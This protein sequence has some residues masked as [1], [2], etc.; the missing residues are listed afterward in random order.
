MYR[1]PCDSP[2][3]RATTASTA[4]SSDHTGAELQV[5]ESGPT[6]V[7]APESGST[8]MTTRSGGSSSEWR[9]LQPSAIRVPLVSHASWVGTGRP[10]PGASTCSISDR[11][12]SKTSVSSAVIESISCH[13][14]VNCRDRGCP[15]RPAPASGCTDAGAIREAR[16]QAP[17]RRSRRVAAR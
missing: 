7:H 16:R 9:T 14:V 8:D 4:P 11:A 15:G 1:A 12:R 10:K 5:H 6:R 2:A 3:E 13:R 17:P